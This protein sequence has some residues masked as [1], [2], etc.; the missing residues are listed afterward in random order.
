[1]ID[2]LFFIQDLAIILVS[3]TIGGFVAQRLG[4]SQVVG[5][6]VA[7][8]IIGTPAI[9]FPHVHDEER[10]L[11]IAQ[12]GVVFLMFSIG[13]RF[14]LERLRELGWLVV[15][16]VVLSAVMIFFIVKSASGWFGLEAAAA[17]A[18][19][20]VFMNSSSAIISKL[21]EEK[22]IGHE[23][24]GQ[25]AMGITLL[26]DIV[27][28]VMLAILGSYLIV[29]QSDA[30][31][32][33][34][35]TIGLLSGF[36]LLVF[37]LG[38]VILPRVFRV[39]SKGK[40]GE[41]LSICVAGLLF[42]MAMLA[43]KA[44]YSIALGAFLFGIIVA[45]TQFRPRVERTFQGLKDIFLTL[46]FVTIGMMVDVTVLPA[47]AKW[48]ALGI[49]GAI[50]L[51][52][53]TA[54]L[55]LL[56]TG[57]HP[58]NAL[59]T[60]ICVTPLGEFSFIIAGVAVAGG[61]F[62]DSFQAI[63][64]G[65]VLGT[66]LISPALISRSDSL[67]AFLAVGKM[68]LLER[69]HQFVVS[70]RAKQTS[71]SSRIRLWPL[72]RKRILQISLELIIVFTA[73]V[74]A[75]RIYE[76]LVQGLGELAYGHWLIVGFW[77]LFGLVCLL[78]L[79]AVWRN[80]AAVSLIV[81]DYLCQAQGF[82]KGA[83]QRIG[84]LLRMV[85]ALLL[86][87]ALWSVLPPQLLGGWL[88]FAIFA[89]L[90]VLLAFLWRDFIRIHSVIAW[91]FQQQLS[92]SKLT[93]AK[94]LFDDWRQQQWNFNIRECLIPDNSLAAGKTLESLALRKTTGC[95]IVGIERQGYRLAR[96]GPRTQLFPG[97]EVLLLGSNEAIGKAEL[98]LQDS[99]NTVSSTIE[100][101]VLKRLTIPDGSSL[102]GKTLADC[103]WSRDYDI[104][105]VAIRSGNNTISGPDA[106]TR[107]HM[108]DDVLLLGTERAMEHLAK[109]LCRA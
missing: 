60:G 7:G 64:V 45:E 47:V 15:L 96:V 62:A 72:L 58:R 104:Q 25:L 83:S 35:D 59:R 61:L 6:I 82:S 50:G 41:A 103:H 8:L 13:L 84:L 4:L 34:L 38:L 107:L 98:L 73:V 9:T 74:F 66:S 30:S 106:K 94:V 24:F 102:H 10:I 11:L 70:H 16:A 29:D 28:V 69:W 43:V 76:G 37:V 108:G 81:S 78:P 93:S 21:L 48:I 101:L 95:S 80:F 22:G 105:V 42:G 26:E 51:R 17:V 88:Y 33:I 67:S 77:L 89:V 23:R 49:A 99:A 54:S 109:N 55:A 20:A 12:L 53:L 31:T 65:V 86:S 39:L 57:E 3:A 56:I 87:I 71:K 1:M 19:A 44:G 91:D 63:V 40:S 90:A 5:Y 97:D 46:F 68:P 100:N 27:A 52:T 36:A 92:E 18:L 32:G 85:F 75:W 79:V 2:P 14:R